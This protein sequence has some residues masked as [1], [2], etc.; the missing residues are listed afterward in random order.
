MMNNTRLRTVPDRAG[1]EGLCYNH[2][3]I[4]QGKK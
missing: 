3:M 2:A 4:K 1:L